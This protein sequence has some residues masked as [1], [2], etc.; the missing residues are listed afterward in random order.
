MISVEEVITDPD[1][2]APRNYTILRS[3]GQFVAGGFQST[4]TPIPMFG[5]VQQSSLKEIDMIPEADRVGAMRSFW[6]TC[7][8]YVT[9][10]Q[11]P[12]P[13]THGEVPAGSG[14]AY[15]LS[16]APPNGAANVY[17]DGLQV[18][19]YTIIGTALTLNDAPV[20]SLYVTWEVTVMV[21]QSASDILQYG[22]EQYRV[23]QVYFDPGGG[24]HKAIATRMAAS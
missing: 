1:M 21:G 10:G 20:A 22:D 7:P 4:V 12:V 18:Q 14:T 11:A 15:T 17:V 2:I 5:P 13:G 24:Y 19:N 23:L 16:S 6:S 9:R 3:Q 8:L